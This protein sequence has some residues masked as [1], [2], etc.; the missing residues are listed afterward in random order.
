LK[1]TQDEAF[2]HDAVEAIGRTRDPALV[3]QVLRGAIAEPL[4]GIESY[5]LMT[6]MLANP[7]ARDLAWAW[8]KRNYSAFVQRIP[9]SA[10][11]DAPWMARWF[12]ST[13]MADDVERFFQKSAGYRPSPRILSMSVESV[14]LCAAF[15]NARGAELRAALIAATTPADS[16]PIGQ[17]PTAPAPASARPVPKPAASKP[18]SEA[19]PVQ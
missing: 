2:R 12:C 9:D 11:A 15:K 16:A 5:D 14:R 10:K 19:A 8:L 18:G 13:D 6:A 3:E 1:N 7:D 4:T 17:K